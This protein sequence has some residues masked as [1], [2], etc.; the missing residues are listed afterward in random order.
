[1]FFLDTL[2]WYC[3]RGYIIQI[4]IFKHYYDSAPKLVA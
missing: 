3:F 4:M 2:L 1:M